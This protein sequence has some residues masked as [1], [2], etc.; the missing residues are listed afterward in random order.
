VEQSKK[1]Q[2]ILSQ[3]SDALNEINATRRAID[4]KIFSLV[5]VTTGLLGV[6][7]AL[8]VWASLRPA[9]QA[10]FVASLIAYV[11][12]VALGL[13]VSYPKKMFIADAHAILEFQDSATYDD[14]SK[15]VAEDILDFV[16]ADAE[17]VD[18][19]ASFLEAM[20]LLICFASVCLV[21]SNIL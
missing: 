1:T 15:W 12:V 4:G 21:I 13:F 6:V 11:G 9:G 7:G 10:L 14:L 2:L 16:D 3:A 20:I 8:G 18:G 17:I 19:K 5:G